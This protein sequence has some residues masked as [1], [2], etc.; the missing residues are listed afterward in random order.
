MVDAAY[1]ETPIG[2]VGRDV[3][4]NVWA[5]IAGHSS[6]RGLY[7]VP[8]VPLVIQ[9][10]VWCHYVFDSTFSLFVGGRSVLETEGLGVGGLERFGEVNIL[11]LAQRRSA[12]DEDSEA[13]VSA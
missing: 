5:Y 13:W 4:E 12:V 1:P 2:H 8:L 9:S 6:L 7:V 10:L 11:G 3:E